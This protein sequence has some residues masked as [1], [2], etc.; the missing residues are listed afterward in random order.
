[1]Y[2]TTSC[3][4]TVGLEENVTYFLDG[5]ARHTGAGFLL[6]VNYTLLPCHVSGTS[7]H[8]KY[9]PTLIISLNDGWAALA[10]AF[11][12]LA[13]LVAF[14]VA[15]ALTA[16]FALASFALV[17]SFAALGLEAVDFVMVFATAIA[18]MLG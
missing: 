9:H 1:M 4:D 2:C 3:K 12:L 16:S 17:A 11:S 13:A 8:T 7:Y 10:T 18:M 14:G 5:G 15:L 6:V